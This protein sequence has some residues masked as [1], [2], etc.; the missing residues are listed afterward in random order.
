MKRKRP[1]RLDIGADDGSEITR[2]NFES[3]NEY[4]T[5]V[6]APTDAPDNERLSQVEWGGSA[7]WHGTETFAQAI[8]LAKRGWPHGAK[9]AETLRASIVD[10][11][12]GEIPIPTIDHDVTGDMIDIGR[13]VSGDPEDFM[14][15]V[16][17]DRNIEALSHP[18]IVR[19]VFNS[20]V[21]NTLDHN[22][23]IQRGVAVM[24]VSD[25]L[26]RHGMRTEIRVISCVSRLVE[27]SIVLK[28]AEE[29]L[30]VDN[31]AYHLAHPSALRRL[32][33][34]AWEHLPEELR[35]RGEF[36]N[37]ASYGRPEEVFR[38]EDRG[39]IYINSF[40]TM[41]GWSKKAMTLWIKAQL[42]ACGIQFE[43]ETT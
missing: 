24:A 29:H 2:Q 25:L 3:V 22:S 43:K 31:A 42:I 15:I 35:R 34:S 19:I 17:S 13:Y 8:D 36:K 21:S 26:E 37:N 16:D 1:S 5:F 18:K 30:D 23:M 10:K 11:I 41:R 4:L 33:T 32:I 7:S 40:T 9:L 6:Q 20:A 39:D 28:R 27:T 12:I 38:K 14:S